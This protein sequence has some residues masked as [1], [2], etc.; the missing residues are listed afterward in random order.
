MY[1]LVVLLLSLSLFS[2][3][4]HAKEIST[5]EVNCPQNLQFIC[6]VAKTIWGNPNLGLFLSSDIAIDSKNPK[7]V[8]IPPPLLEP[9][10]HLILVLALVFS[11]FFCYHL[12]S[13]FS[14]D[15]DALISLVTTIGGPSV[16]LAYVN[17]YAQ[18]DINVNWQVTQLLSV[19]FFDCVFACLLRVMTIFL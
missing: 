15:V 12:S 9:I 5:R 7:V 17:A 3:F 6:D 16:F 1:L 19:F 14:Q 13:A 11:S 18:W 2:G 10:L 4:S 8:L